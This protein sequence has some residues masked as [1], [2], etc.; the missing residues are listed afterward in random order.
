[1]IFN[2]NAINSI[3]NQAYCNFFETINFPNS[4]LL[5]LSWI[6]AFFWKM[7]IKHIRRMSRI[8]D[9]RFETGHTF[10]AKWTFFWYCC[11]KLYKL[12]FN[13]FDTF[14][15]QLN[16]IVDIFDMYNVLPRLCMCWLD[17]RIYYYHNNNFYYYYYY[18]W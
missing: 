6:Y 3:V 1:M 18:Y 9:L 2:K 5:I 15:L 8:F 7:N 14:K 13:C 12:T 17:Q 4:Y 11:S 10:Q 16:S